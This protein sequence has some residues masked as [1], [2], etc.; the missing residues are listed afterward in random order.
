MSRMPT[1]VHIRPWRGMTPPF[2]LERVGCTPVEGLRNG[3]GAGDA[4]LPPQV[5]HR[6][7]EDEMVVRGER[8]RI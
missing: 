4:G 8:P 5:A 2:D 1:I 3:S 7:T 6:V